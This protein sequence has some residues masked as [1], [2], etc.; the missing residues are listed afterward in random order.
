[1]IFF[2]GSSGFQAKE[3][4]LTIVNC[5]IFTCDLEN[6]GHAMVSRN[7]K[8]HV[9]HDVT[10]SFKVISKSHASGNSYN[11]FLDLKTLRS[12]KKFIAVGQIQAKIT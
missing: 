2:F 6:E 3:I 7:N 10:L 4:I 5:V 12:N 1:M 8:R 9:D 11:E